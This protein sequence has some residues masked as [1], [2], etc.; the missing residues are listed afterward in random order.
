MTPENFN[1]SVKSVSSVLQISE[2]QLFSRS[3]E[4]PIVDARHILFYLC[5]KRHGMPLVYIKKYMS[6]RGHT[7]H[8]ATIKHGIDKVRGLLDVDHINI[9]IFK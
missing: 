1:T 2:E 6:E 4:K 9:S 3:R 8:H 5:N 7:V